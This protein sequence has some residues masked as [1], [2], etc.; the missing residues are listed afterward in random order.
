[1]Q[2]HDLSD[3]FLNAIHAGAT[4][5]PQQVRPA[6]RTIDKTNALR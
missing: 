5:V 4:P 1:M 2:V 6:G 3:E